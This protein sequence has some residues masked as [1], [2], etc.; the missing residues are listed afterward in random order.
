MGTLVRNG[1]KSSY[2]YFTMTNHLTDD[3]DDTDDL[4]DD[5]HVTD[6]LTD[7]TD[8]DVILFEKGA[9]NYNM[10]SEIFRIF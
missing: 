4:T 2:M 3:T 5:T 6:D 1:L 7:N 10:S 8:E 9:F